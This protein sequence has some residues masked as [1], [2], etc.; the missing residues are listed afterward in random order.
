MGS[1]TQE[2]RGTTLPRQ[3]RLQVLFICSMNQWRSRTAEDVY[4][5]RH[6]LDVRSRGTRRQARQRV[7][8]AD[9]KWADVVLV[10]E[11]KH[12][13]RLRAE[14][15]GETRFVDIHVLDVPDEYRHMDPELV[16]ALQVAVDPIL[17]AYSA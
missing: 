9:L 1:A 17:A 13:R 12:E 10:M 2:T 15:P 6:D 4:R 11:P 7:R 16:V 14:F 5:R 3:P 8:A